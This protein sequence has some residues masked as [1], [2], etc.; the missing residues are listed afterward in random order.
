[1]QSPG[2]IRIAIQEELQNLLR[3]LLPRLRKGVQVEIGERPQGLLGL[4]SRRTGFQ[5]LLVERL[6]LLDLRLGKT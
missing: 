6:P 5:N 3:R 2:R 1:M 4:L